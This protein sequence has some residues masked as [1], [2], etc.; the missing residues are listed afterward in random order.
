MTLLAQFMT[1]H[2]AP[3]GRPTTAIKLANFVVFQ[4]AWFAAVIGAA[5]GAPLLGIASVAVAIGWHLMVSERALP[6]AC[7]VTLAMALGL[8]IETLQLSAGTIVYASSAPHAVLAP[9]WIVSLWGLFAMALNVT[10]RWL[11]H[12]GWLAV[13]LGAVCGPLSFASGVRMGAAR[14]VETRPAL[15]ILALAWAVALPLLVWLSIRFDGVAP[16]ALQR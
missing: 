1:A 6:E 2:A 14:F 11:R 7:L 10:L 4:L 16:E 9:A 5:R 13:L 8:G 12:R 15:L 3:P